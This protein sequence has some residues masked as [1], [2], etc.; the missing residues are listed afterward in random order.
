MAVALF[1]VSL[2]NYTLFFIFYFLWSRLKIVILLYDASTTF[3][4][5]VRCLQCKHLATF[6]RSVLHTLCILYTKTLYFLHQQ[7]EKLACVLYTRAYYMRDFT[8][9]SSVS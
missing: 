5:A 6:A 2:N 9:M 3:N 8:V 4:V 1:I 7:T